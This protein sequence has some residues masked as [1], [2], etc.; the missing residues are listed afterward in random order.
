MVA[1]SLLTRLTVEGIKELSKNNS[2]LP[3]R[4]GA[5]PREAVNNVQYSCIGCCYLRFPPTPPSRQNKDP[6]FFTL[7]G[8][9]NR[10]ND[11]CSDLAPHRLPR[12]F[13]GFADA[14]A[15]SCAT[16][17]PTHSREIPGKNAMRLLFSNPGLLKL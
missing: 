12:S 6:H 11:L 10:P 15:A 14:I 17:V 16:T 1:A 4:I 3:P 7:R 2:H 13:K 9:Q 8:A 5:H